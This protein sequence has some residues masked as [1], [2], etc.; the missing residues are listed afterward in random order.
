MAGSQSKENEVK[1][2]EIS[3]SVESRRDNLGTFLALHKYF[4]LCG[5]GRK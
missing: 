2:A 3:C 4:N 1:E 5:E